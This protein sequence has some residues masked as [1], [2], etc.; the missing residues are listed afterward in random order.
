MRVYARLHDVIMIVLSGPPHESLAAELARGSIQGWA[1]SQQECSM[2]SLIC[3]YSSSFFSGPSHFSS[4]LSSC[5]TAAILEPLLQVD[6][7]RP[8]QLFLL[9]G[10]MLLCALHVGLEELLAFLQSLPAH[11]WVLQKG[12]RGGRKGKRGPL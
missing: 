10:Q 2:A 5:G 6:L 12:G 7:R 3:H 4:S 8:V 1:G 11:G 9:A